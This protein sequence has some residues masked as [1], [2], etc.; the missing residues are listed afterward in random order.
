MNFLNCLKLDYNTLNIRLYII[1]K[2]Q[3][4]ILII[5]DYETSLILCYKL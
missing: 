5:S 1:N 2:T 4:K 3:F